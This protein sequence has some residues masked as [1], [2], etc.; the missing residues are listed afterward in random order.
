MSAEIN[1]CS[2]PFNA[3]GDG[4]TDDRKAIQAAIDYVYKNGG[5]TVTLDAGRIF[6]SGGIIIKSGVTLNFGEGAV[7]Q[8][9]KT[10]DGYVKP[11]GDGYVSYTPRPGHNFDEKIKWSHYWYKNYPF[12]FAPEGSHDFKITGS[13]TVRMAEVDEPEKLI[14]LCPVGFYRC[15]NFEIS[16]ITITDYH[17]YAM[18]PFT[19]ENGLIKNVKINHWSHGNGD[20]ICLMN[21]KNIRITG[22][23]MFT[24]DDSVYIFSSCRDPR[25]SEWWN[26]DEPCPSENIEIDN[27]DLISNHCKAFGMILWGLNCEDQEKVEVRNVYVHD[28]HIE[29]LGN[30]LWNPYTDRAGFPPVT[31]VRFENNVIDGIEENFFETQISDMTG[32]PS[33][34]RMINGDFSQGRCFWNMIK[35]ESENSA[36]VCR[37]DGNSYGYIDELSL[38]DAAVFQGVY[39]ESGKPCL[40]KAQVMSSGDKCRLFI[41]SQ[42]SGE[43]VACL[44][45]SDTD[46]CEKELEFSVPESGNYRLGLERGEA[47]DGFARIRAAA[48]G[49]NENAKGYE[50]VISDNGK[51]IYK[52]NDNLFRR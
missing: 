18:M 26:S 27:N 42:S 14:K 23:K 44:D 4:K 36:G 40:F 41:R 20:G 19:S 21:C 11:V 30:W 2:S 12:I 9:K 1:V 25:R 28:N 31:A 48:L 46:W 22:C 37:E 24:G 16:D 3:A 49:S 35:N 8:Q 43:T 50:K 10:A 29:T 52:Y 5:G 32:F 17:A 51:I 38:G 15:K 39:I 34:R 45:F 47:K 33:M 7:L 6:M 13:G